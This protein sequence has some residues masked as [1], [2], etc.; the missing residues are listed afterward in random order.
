MRK[1]H[2]VSILR[3]LHCLQ[4]LSASFQEASAQET[5]VSLCVQAHFPW[6]AQCVDCFCSPSLLTAHFLESVRWTRA[7]VLSSFTWGI[8]R[9]R[10]SSNGPLMSPRDSS[11]AL[12]R[13]LGVR[14]EGRW[15]ERERPGP[16]ALLLHLYSSSHPETMWCMHANM[17]RFSGC[18]GIKANVL[19]QPPILL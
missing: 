5:P 14:D 8:S 2:L 10:R 19:P 4:H 1:E 11:P 12:H 9:S 17:E 18:G 13:R 3:R 16:P 7:P 15:R 6:P